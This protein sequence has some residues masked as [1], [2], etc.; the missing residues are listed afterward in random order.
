VVRH[1]DLFSGIGGFALAASRVWGEE[2]QNVGHSE[3]EKFPCQV[4]HKHFP[5]SRCLGDITK[6]KWERAIADTTNDGFSSPKRRRGDGKADVGG[7]EGK[8]EGGDSEGRNGVRIDLVT[9]GFPCQPFSVAGKRRGKG[10]DRFLWHEMLRA[11]QEVKPRWVVGEN[12]PGIINLAL[13]EVLSSLEAEGYATETYLIPAVGLNAPHKR[14]R[15]W[16]VA[17][18]HSKNNPAIDVVSD[19]NS[20]STGLERWSGN[21]S[22]QGRGRLGQESW[23]QSWLEV[24]TR[25]C[26]VD[27]GLPRVVDRVARLKALGNAIVPQV[28]QVILQAIKDSDGNHNIPIPKNKV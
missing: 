12:V 27:D 16:I 24:A 5:E 3:I 15:V 23:E 17:H 2:Y 20:K 7:E 22:A 11:I 10:D 28:A 25:L 21:E 26:R 1:I 19:S 6:I 9:G 14:E 8:E 18:E 4:Y 13:D